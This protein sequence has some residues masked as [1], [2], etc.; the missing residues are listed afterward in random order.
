MATDRF[1]T[2][3]L[4]AGIV[5]NGGVYRTEVR[6]APRQGLVDLWWSAFIAGRLLGV[7]VDVHTS[8][9]FTRGTE[10]PVVAVEVHVRVSVAA[11][12]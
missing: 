5:G 3:R 10:P 4:I 9:P 1:A 6:P 8:A 2:A 11:T 7:P 12:G